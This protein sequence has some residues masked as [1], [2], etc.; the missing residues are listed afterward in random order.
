M[1]GVP[2]QIRPNYKRFGPYLLRLCY[3][4]YLPEKDSTFS[5]SGLRRRKERETRTLVSVYLG[6]VEPDLFVYRVV[7][8][9][10]L[11]T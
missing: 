11:G 4:V 9:D 10:W 5:Q 1:L 3:I 8:M 2:F 7:L 6:T